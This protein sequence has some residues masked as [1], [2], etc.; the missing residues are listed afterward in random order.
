M[1]RFGPLAAALLVL[2]GG[3]LGGGRPKETPSG[4]DSAPATPGPPRNGTSPPATNPTG[5]NPPPATGS[6]NTTAPS[7]PPWPAAN[8]G[9]IRPGVRI[10]YVGSSCTSNFIYR[11]PDNATLYLGAAA[12]CFDGAELND[13]V[14]IDAL[15]GTTKQGILA[16]SS[17]IALGLGPCQNAAGLSCGGEYEKDFALVALNNSY[18]SIVHPAVRHFGGPVG[19]ADAGTL[20]LGDEVVSYGNTDLRPGVLS[21]LNPRQGVVVAPQGDEPK[22]Q[23]AAV[24]PALPGDSG[25]AVMTSDG[26]AVGVLVDISIAPPGLNGI[27]GLKKALDLAKE[28]TGLDV[29]VATWPDFDASILP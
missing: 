20:G 14:A 3:C 21:T 29:E 13:T 5:A 15:D 26:R 19:F 1:S 2:L 12:H 11:S 4:S 23:V 9:Q 22:F 17:W 8:N 18:R 27:T 6:N 24:T 25:S 16:Y 10:E 28:R 7:W